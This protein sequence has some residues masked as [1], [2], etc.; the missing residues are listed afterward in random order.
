[1]IEDIDI[2]SHIINNHNN[3]NKIILLL[4]GSTI[5]KSRK[6]TNI[7][8]LEKNI[9]HIQREKIKNANIEYLN[10]LNYI[11]TVET[12]EISKILLEKIN[13]FDCGF[14]LNHIINNNLQKDKSKLVF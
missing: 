7:Y 4:S 10:F 13:Y 5:F 9:N 3:I 14:M 11:E 2:E 6:C 8:N 12:V 1:M